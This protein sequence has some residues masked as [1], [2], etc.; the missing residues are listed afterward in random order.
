MRW[1]GALIVNVNR[2][3]R[4]SAISPRDLMELPGDEPQVEHI[5]SKERFEFLKSRWN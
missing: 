2:D 1:L 4:R 5:M 3:S